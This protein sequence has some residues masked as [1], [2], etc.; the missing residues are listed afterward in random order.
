MNKLV[1]R[2]AATM[3]AALAVAAMG[4][5]AAAQDEKIT[6]EGLIFF[7]R[8]STAKYD[9]G[10][11]L[12]TS[13]PGVRVMNLDTREVV[14]TVKPGADGRYKVENLPKGPKYSLFALDTYYYVGTNRTTWEL[15]EGRADADFPIRGV[16]VRGFTF[17]DANGDG[18]RQPDEQT[19][20]GASGPRAR[21]VGKGG[22]GTD[23]DVDAS[24]TADD[25][26]FRIDDLPAGKYDFI[27]PDFRYRQLSLAKPKSDVDVDWVTGVK[28]LEVGNGQDVRI[29]TRYFKPV[30]DF[31][32][33]TPV[34]TPAKDTYNVDEEVDVL[35]RIKNNGQAPDKTSFVLASFAA[36]TLA[37]TPNVKA[38]DNRNDEFE[39][40]NRLLPGETAD[41]KLR[42]KLNSTE[43][44][45]VHLIVRPSPDYRDVK[46]SD[47][48]A[49]KPIK[50]VVPSTTSPTET[51]TPT[52]TTTTTTA[53]IAA[54]KKSGLASTGA[55]PLGF[56]GIGGLL[57][58]IGALVTVLARK[59]RA[60]T[61]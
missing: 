31:V 37:T 39:F 48:V 6:I 36:K 26:S 55:S 9:A 47:N 24:P 33:S 15:S 45:A 10:D 27:A 1:G 57:L 17:V 2:I 34:I 58:A 40:V 30:G 3:T 41:V 23:V 14:A 38:I 21:L 8:N 32:A 49:I 56:I 29:D 43:L 16:T 11:G 60:A 44:E 54:P 42:I 20:P 22:D 19:L 25:A 46:F 7:D 4:G 35:L 5:T 50:V 52:T 51:T 12:R 28:K 61:K 59:R 18:V 53:V 13:G